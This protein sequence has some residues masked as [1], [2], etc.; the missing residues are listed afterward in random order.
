MNKIQIVASVVILLDHPG[1]DGKKQERAEVAQTCISKLGT[2][3]VC[4][5]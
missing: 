1:S 3:K 4:S 5:R 2:H